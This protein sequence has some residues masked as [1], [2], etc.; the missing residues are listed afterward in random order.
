MESQTI[1][2]LGGDDTI[3]VDDLDPAALDELVVNGGAGDDTVRLRAWAG[4]SL[5][6]LNGGDGADTFILGSAGGATGTLRTEPAVIR[7]NGGD[8]ADT[9]EIFEVFVETVVDLFG[10]AGPDTFNLRP[11]G[12]SSEGTLAGINDDP[13]DVSVSVTRQL[14]IDGGDS[15]GL[16]P[17]V[18]RTVNEGAQIDNNDDGTP[19]AAPYNEDSRLLESAPCDPL[20]MD[21]IH[22]D[23]DESSATGDTINLIADS[24]SDELDLRLLVTSL[25]AG[26]L[27]TVDNANPEA[28]AN[29][30]SEY[31][32]IESVNVIGGAGHDSL[33][34]HSDVAI[35]ASSTGMVITFDGGPGNDLLRV[36]GTEFDDRITIRSPIVTG[37]TRAPFEVANV[38]FVRVDGFGGDDQIVNKTSALAVLNGGEGDDVIVGGS[39]SDLITGGAGIDALFGCE[40]NDILLPDQAFGDNEPDPA[41]VVDAELIDG[42]PEDSL[43]PGDVAIQVGED[44]VDDIE[45]LG[46]G[47]GIKNVLT[48]IKAIFIPRDSVAFDGS[49]LLVEAFGRALAD[50]PE[51]NRDNLFG[52]ADE[53]AASTQGSV[54]Q[55]TSILQTLH[56]DVLPADVTGDGIVSALDAL[57]VVNHLAQDGAASAGEGESP[58]LYTF[59]DVNSDDRVTALDALLVINALHRE[60]AGT[61]GSANL[62]EGE[63]TTLAEV[64]VPKAPASLRTDDS[65]EPDWLELLADDVARRAGKRVT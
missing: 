21:E 8:G 25:G 39:A 33:T 18:T 27:A 44:F 31:I 59:P 12:S 22:M 30:A 28:P 15:I 41:I 64:A 54:V 51:L 1:N 14:F 9:F 34:I 4:A 52:E 43:N 63:S 48:W 32:G 55:T 47:G 5:A 40:G 57:T 24:A 50:P 45:S 3:T 62:A 46:D 35:T 16:G 49:T 6:E 37:S 61:S 38:E 42:G 20:G 36:I 60:S 7:A 29:E 11:S 53:T 13:D 10:G 19:D 26:A 58:L 56:N 65:S 17:D 23:N 2:G